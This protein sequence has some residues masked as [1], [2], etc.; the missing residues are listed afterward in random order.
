[1]SLAALTS[2]APRPAPALAGDK[3]SPPAEPAELKKAC[4]M[5]ESLYL[6]MLWKSMRRTVDKTGL[7]DGGFGEEI[8]TDLLDQAVSDRFVEGGSMGIAD[9]LEKQLSRRPGTKPGVGIGR[10]L[11][12]IQR[13]PPL[14]LPVPGRITSPFGP[15]RH[16]VT[17][18]HRQHQGL[19]LAAPEGTPVHAARAGVVVF[20]GRR[21]DYGNLVVVEHADGSSTY[22][23]HCRD[24]LVSPGERVDA[25]QV[26]ATVGSTGL[27]TGP[28]L[29][30]ELRDP[31]GRPRDPMPRL[32][33]GLSRTS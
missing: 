15:R 9:M 1:M 10:Y 19:D 20:S 33:A 26:L 11:E 22:Y 12:G 13:K 4:R 17:G 7:M 18:R 3:K 21:G 30:F 32:A 2:P 24:L 6:Q 16:P 31:Q 29:H 27:S 28:H 14:R 8:F 23:G 25:D 5:F